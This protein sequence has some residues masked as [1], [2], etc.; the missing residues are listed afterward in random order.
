MSSASGLDVARMTRLPVLV[1]L[2]DGELPK[3]NDWVEA[4]GTLETVKEGDYEYIALHLSS[5]TVLEERGAEYVS[6]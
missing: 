2:Y 6:H 4:V 3:V 1:I 5:L